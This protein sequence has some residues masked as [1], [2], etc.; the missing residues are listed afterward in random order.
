MIDAI[1]PR[2]GQANTLRTDLQSKGN[3]TMKEE[4]EMQGK[5]SGLRLKRICY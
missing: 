3:E 5:L 4:E 2:V 1:L